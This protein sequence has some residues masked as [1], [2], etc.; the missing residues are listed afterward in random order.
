MPDKGVI[1]VAKNSLRQSVDPTAPSP[2]EISRNWLEQNMGRL[3]YEPIE[4]ELL[5]AR[6]EL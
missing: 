3:N 5:L 4:P 6:T 2:Q 1:L